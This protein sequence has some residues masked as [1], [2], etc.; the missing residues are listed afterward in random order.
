MLEA[1]L[2]AL[3]RDTD[4]AVRASPVW[5]AAE[6]LHSSVPGTADVTARPLVA[7]LPDLGRRR[8]VALVGVARLNGA[9]G[10][11]RG[12]QAIA[13]P[14][15]GAQHP[16]HG[17]PDS[18]PPEPRHRAHYSRMATAGRLEKLA[19]VARIGHLPTTLNAI[20]RTQAP[21]QK[22]RPAAT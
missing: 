20:L 13:G 15:L 8:I 16:L 7:E 5:R 1:R 14:H 4:G 9:Y 12:H 18:P 3:D 22:A 11:R 19:M 21:R 10:Q 2:A 17:N 6:E